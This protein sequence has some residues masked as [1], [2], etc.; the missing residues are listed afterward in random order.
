MYPMQQ[1]LS[2]ASD[3]YNNEISVESIDPQTPIQIQYG[4]KAYCPSSLRCYVAHTTIVMKQMDTHYKA[5][6]VEKQ[7]DKSSL[8]S[9]YEEH[10]Q[11]KKQA[12]TAHDFDEF[13]IHPKTD[14]AI[15]ITKKNV[16]LQKSEQ[17]VVRFTFKLVAPQIIVDCENK[18]TN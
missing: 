7:S 5:C 10:S 3:Y 16:S 11:E 12:I 18:P 14:D 17:E 2:I 9:F 4:T 15:I 6:F 13:I 1:K 8:I